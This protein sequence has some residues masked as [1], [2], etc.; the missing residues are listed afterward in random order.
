LQNPFYER[1][2]EAERYWR[3][4]LEAQAGKVKDVSL[5]KAFYRRVASMHHGD[6]GGLIAQMD[7]D[8]NIHMAPCWEGLKMRWSAASPHSS[9]ACIRSM[10]S[11]RW[12]LATAPSKARPRTMWRR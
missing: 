2:M 4:Q 1:A 9:A 10:K 3:Q 6:I 7:L 12:V 8:A 5:Y 11:R